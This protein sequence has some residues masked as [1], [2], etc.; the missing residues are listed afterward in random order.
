MIKDEFF[1]LI[2]RLPNASD[3]ERD[4]L[5][6]QVWE[7][8]GVER[9]VMALDMSHFSLTVRRSGI[10]G[11]L[12][13][14]RRMQVI[15]KPIVE[16]HGG[17]LVEFH[18]DNLMAVFPDV[19]QAVDAG[20]AMNRAFELQVKSDGAQMIQVAIGIDF[21]RFLFVDGCRCFGDTV[22]T[23]FKLGEDLARAGEILLTHGA[24][25]RLGTTFPHPFSEQRFSISGLELNTFNVQHR[26][27]K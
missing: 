17:A 23:A 19:P 20:I 8:F 4:S 11:Y 16:A 10:L 13:L 9:A 15:T 25:A 21:G 3:A 7:R 22:N 6:A 26:N 1:S 12:G 27:P 18:A 2:D 14:I 5:E 24:R